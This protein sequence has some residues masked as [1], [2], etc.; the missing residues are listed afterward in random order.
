MAEAPRYRIK[1]LASGVPGLDEV[2]GGGFPEFS[3]NLI[4]GGPGAGKTTLALQVMF[5]TASAERPALYFTL[6]GEPTLKLLRYQ[7]QF[8]FFD[9]ERVGTEIRFVNLSEEVL[10]GN[11]VPVLDRIVAEVERTRPSVVVIDSF[12]TLSRGGSPAAGPQYELEH[13]VQRLAL[14]L[15]TWEVTSFLIGEYTDAEVRNPVFTVADGVLWLSQAV[16]R[17]SVVRKLQVVK[18]RGLATMPGLH[19]VRM[20]GAGVQVFPRIPERPESAAPIPGARLSTG[21]AG[22][23]DM[24]GGGI[25]AGD[26]AVV[27]GPTGTGKSTFGTQFIA[28]GLRRGEPG[29]IAV[30]EEHPAEYLR[31]AKSYGVDLEEAVRRNQLKIIYVRPLDLSVDETL[32]EIRAEVRRLGAKRVVIDSLSGFEMALAP[33]FR[34]DFRE[35]LYRLVSALTGVGVTVLMTV[36]MVGEQRNIQFSNYQVSFLTDDIITQRYVEI[37]GHLQKVLAVVK[38]RGSR[39]SREF[40]A[41]DIT[42]TGIHLG[43][44]LRGYDAITSGIPRREARPPEVRFPGLTSG[45]VLVLEML[46]LVPE[47]SAAELAERIGAAPETLEVALTRLLEL[48]YA[49]RAATPAGNRYRAMARPNTS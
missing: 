29:V 39:H 3:F 32:A 27:A 5:A 16:D 48:G 20:S 7:Q 19:T 28:E 37:E 2:L 46:L 24:M 23:D 36:E 38:M 30:F 18:M 17:N 40:R 22:L 47:S 1:L 34:E 6:L 49:S 45:E 8:S 35:S 41:Y 13:F 15:T 11:L 4:A 9:T 14:H 33:T 10:H 42:A 26:S 43:E 21:I 31:R 25:P 44:L 12:R